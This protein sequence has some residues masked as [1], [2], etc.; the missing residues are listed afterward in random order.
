MPVISR[1]FL[2]AE[3]ASLQSHS[4]K[5]F[6]LGLV[7]VSQVGL[8]MEKAGEKLGP[9]CLKSKSLPKKVHFMQLS[10]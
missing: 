3:V 7:K 4:M 1:S 5:G 2:S 10:L 8:K 6:L 9:N